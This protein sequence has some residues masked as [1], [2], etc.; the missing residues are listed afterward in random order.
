MHLFHSCCLM[1]YILLM[2]THVLYSPHRT[3]LYVTCVISAYTCSS[4]LAGDAEMQMLLFMIHFKALLFVLKLF[5]NGR[6][7]FGGDA[8]ICP[9]SSNDRQKIIPLTSSD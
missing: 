2:L 6:E 7:Y 5:L 8:V 3:S 4:Y 1:L 9:T